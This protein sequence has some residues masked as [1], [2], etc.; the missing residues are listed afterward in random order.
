M[1]R[2]IC[3]NCDNLSCET[4]VCPVCGKRTE[5]ISTEVFYCEKCN[6]PIFD[7]V[8]PICGSKGNKIGSDLRPVFSEER[9]L[10][11]VLQKS[12]FKYAGH[13]VWK[14]AWYRVA[15]GGDFARAAWAVRI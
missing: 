4:S 14:K 9:L 10:L 6:C 15:G 7:E 8:C 1:Q 5:L 2:Y 13:S 3:S 11:E 12:P